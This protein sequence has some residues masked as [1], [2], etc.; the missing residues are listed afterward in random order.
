VLQKGREWREA[1]RKE[2]LGYAAESNMR[3]LTIDIETS[4]TL[5]H[6]W[7]I[8]KENVGINQII[9]K[10][11]VI[12]FAA[13]W[14]NHP[15]VDCF[16]IHHD[17][18]DRMLGELHT[19]LDEADAVIHFNGKR[20]DIPHINREFIMNDYSPPSP[21]KQ[22]DLLECVKRKFRFLS[23]RLVYVA[24][25]LEIGEKY[26]H[27]KYSGHRLWLECVE[28]NNPDAWKEMRVYNK[29]DVV[30][31]ELLYHRLLPWI[32]GH[33]NH[34]LYADGS[35]QLCPQCGSDDMREGK[36][37]PLTAGL[38]A[39]YTC[40]NCGRNLRGRYTLL[41]KE[42]RKNLTTGVAGG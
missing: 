19:Y 28:H 13:K 32:E 17:G 34:N 10:T 24:E 31:T 25:Q 40:N 16:D 12:S 26:E 14:L 21:Y 23:N 5:A 6:I 41:T 7:K 2:E 11:E 39:G 38:Y 36:P 18:K 3:L 27:G 33:P 37:V 30:L 35:K 4:P 9:D 29:Q 42:S 22:I 8:W 20:F 15:H 1:K